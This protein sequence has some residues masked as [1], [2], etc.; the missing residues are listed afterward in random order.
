MKVVVFDPNRAAPPPHPPAPPLAVFAACLLYYCFRPSLDEPTRLPMAAV[1]LSTA[2]V[3]MDMSQPIDISSLV[4]TGSSPER[5]DDTAAAMDYTR[6]A[7]LH[8][9]LV[10]L[11]WVGSVMAQKNQPN[12]TNTNNNNSHDSGEADEARSRLS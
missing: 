4:V 7:A 12:Q 9:Y 3:D 8:I 11:G 5:R 1:P 10:Q 2:T 6:C